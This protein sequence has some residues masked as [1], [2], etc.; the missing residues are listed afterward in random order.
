MQLP[1]SLQ[2]RLGIG[3]TVG[4]T[5]FW[6]VALAGAVFAARNQLNARFDSALAETAQR[7]MPLA[8]VEVINREDR[9]RA[10]HIVAFEAHDEPLVYLV[11]DR[12]G[13]ILLQS[14]NAEP[15]VFNREL[16]AGFSS[17]PTHRFYGAWAVQGSLHIEVAEPLAQ[18][19]EAIRATAASLLWPLVV[20]APLCFV[21]SWAFVRYSLRPVLAYR[22]AIESRGSGDLSP[23]S[24]QDLPTE[25]LTIAA[26]VNQLLERLRRALEAE[27]SFTANSAHELRTPIATALAQTQR[28]QRELSPGKTRDRALGIEMSLRKL[29]E[30]SEKLMQLAKAEGGGLLSTRQHDLA[31]LLQLI[32]DDLRQ[33]PAADRIELAL[34]ESGACMRALDPD[35]FAILA[36]NLLD[37]ALKHG[38]AEQPVE[39]SLSPAGVLRIVNAGDIIPAGELAQLRR[40]FVRSKTTARGAGLGLAIADAVVTGV[41]ASMEL[42]SPASGRADGFEVRITFPVTGA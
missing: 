10:Q 3:L 39:V 25:I 12:G 31:G 21:G 14:H 23:V 18:R 17:S 8:V 38:S 6:L 30:L 22:D 15:A 34:P 37:N 20:L 19:R 33:S 28:L 42:C 2:T 11:R 36:R 5:L 29:S 27:R 26:S 4:V 41:G 13:Q 35:A 24:V 32:V 16:R 40:R 7:I 9:S 1:R